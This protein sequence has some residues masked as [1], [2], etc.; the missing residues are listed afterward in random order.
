MAHFIGLVV[1]LHCC[2]SRHSNRSGCAQN[3][4]TT[5]IAGPKFYCPQMVDL[6]DEWTACGHASATN[7]SSDSNDPRDGD[8]DGHKRAIC[9]EWLLDYPHQI[10]QPQITSDSGVHPSMKGHQFIVFLSFRSFH[11]FSRTSDRGKKER[12]RVLAIYHHVW[13][14]FVANRFRMN[15]SFLVFSGQHSQI[16]SNHKIGTLSCSASVHCA[17][18]IIDTEYPWDQSKWPLTSLVVASCSRCGLS[19]RTRRG[20]ALERC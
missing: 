14:Q 19:R 2:S 7:R 18:P 13:T 6:M 15:R 5:S 20:T 4:S 12:R 11:H 9:R 16:M 8:Y 3:N 1:A 10:P 17:L